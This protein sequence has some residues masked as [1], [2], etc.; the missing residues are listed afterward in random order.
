MTPS[1][2]DLLFFD[3]EEEPSPPPTKKSSTWKVLVVDDEE[4]VHQVTRLALGGLEIDGHPLE[5]LHARSAAEGRGCVEAHP[6]LALAILDVVMETTEAGL[7]LAAWI[8]GNP[9]NDLLRVILR[10]GQPG[11]APEA[12]VMARYD[13]HD[14]H[15]KTELSAQRLRTA[16]TGGVRAHRDIK[17]IALQRLGLEK[18]LEATATLFAP[19]QL[20]ALLAGILEQIAALLL[21]REHAVFFLARPP[22]FAPAEPTEVVLAASGRYADRVGQSVAG[23][24]PPA[25][26]ERTSRLPLDG[27]WHY[28]DHDGL[29]A[30]D[31]GEGV[32]PTLFLEAARSLSDW[33][34]KVL[35]LFCSSAAMALR[36]KRLFVERE[37]YLTAFERFVPKAFVELLGHRDVRSVSV[38]DQ[39]FRE[40]S[41][42]FV[43]VRG[44][45]GRSE[46]LG[47]AGTFS[48]V[49][50]LFACLV[51]IA[52][53]HGAV[54][55]K[56]QGDGVMIL[57]PNGPQAALAAAVEM[58]QTLDALNEEAP[59]PGGAVTL[60]IS[61][62]HG[63]VTVGT[64]GHAARFD[65]TVISDVANV[66]AR[67][68]DLCRA[69]QAPIL[70]AEEALAHAALDADAFRR[71][72]AFALRGREQPVGVYEALTADPPPTQQAKRETRPT[73]DAAVDLRERGL[74]LEAAAAFDTVVHVNPAD[75]TA[76]WL[77]T[78]CRERS[79]QRPPNA[80]QG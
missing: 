74:W 70:I 27:A 42:V 39:V 18:V 52:A 8:R 3:E 24:L 50:R 43:D 54:I 30:L 29:L 17:T 19:R 78:D 36:N 47:P 31:L 10:T 59:L 34:R 58:H 21:P 11:L 75:R 55:D 80:G 64:V 67:L 33:E 40:M 38:G 73:F 66:A 13:I 7:E 26:L 51:P 32:R 45:T 77:A 1:D 14:Y 57:F 69:F 62:Q 60:G 6:D 49:N 65:T 15:S 79:A 25:V 44:F 61:V 71:L 37:E 56:Y 28:V 5:L 46:R 16:I 63:P 2:D 48:F 20:E 76:R 35:T 4:G 72:G 9:K 22:L 41:V 12:E 53:R 68:Q 23:V